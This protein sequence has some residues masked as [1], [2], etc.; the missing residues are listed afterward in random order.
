MRR[1][2]K[3][4]VE[5]EKGREGESREEAGHDHIGGWGEERG[6]GKAQEGKREAN[7]SKREGGGASSPFYTELGLPGYYQVIV[8]SRLP[9]YCQVTVGWSLDRTLTL[10]PQ[11][12]SICKMWSLY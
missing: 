10:S 9:G 5:A 1:G 12:G 11:C 2:V 7:R 8:G 3:R 4:V 6:K